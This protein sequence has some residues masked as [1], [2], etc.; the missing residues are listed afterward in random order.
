M[1]NLFSLLMVFPLYANAQISFTPKIG[2]EYSGISYYPKHSQKNHDIRTTIPDGEIFLSFE[3]GLIIKK[4]KFSLLIERMN[5]GEGIKI[6]RDSAFFA[7]GFVG[8]GATRQITGRNILY[9]G[10]RRLFFYYGMGV[11]IGF[12]KDS[13]YYREVQNAGYSSSYWGGDNPISIQRWAYP[14]GHGIFVNIRG[15]LSLL[16]KKKK[17]VVILNIFWRHGL[18]KMVEYTADYSYSSVLNPSYSRTVIGY[19]F[20][21]RGTTF[22]TTIG[23]PIYTSKKTIK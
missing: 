8:S 3:I 12:N 22:G 9:L 20:N 15:G 23:F 19:R 18:R 21:N 17:E 5:L 4:Q 13:A 7:N 6:K 1:K 11:G 10:S 16:N 14:T 2:F